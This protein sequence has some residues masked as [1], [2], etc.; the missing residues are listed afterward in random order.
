MSDAWEPCDDCNCDREGVR[1]PQDMS[2]YRDWFCA[3]CGLRATIKPE[4]HIEGLV[5]LVCPRCGRDLA[6]LNPVGMDGYGSVV[7]FQRGWEGCHN[8]KGTG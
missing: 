6:P 8:P 4:N 3:G 1:D 5:A 7:L 2:Q